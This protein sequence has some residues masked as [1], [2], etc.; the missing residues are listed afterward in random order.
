MWRLRLE[1][2]PSQGSASCSP[3]CGVMPL[4]VSLPRS[5]IL[6][7]SLSLCLSIP[8]LLGRG[9]GR[10]SGLEQNA[11]KATGRMRSDG[12]SRE[13]CGLLTWG[14]FFKMCNFAAA[15]TD[16]FTKG[17]LRCSDTLA[18]APCDAVGWLVPSSA[19]P[20]TIGAMR[21]GKP[22]IILMKGMV[23]QAA[24]SRAMQQ[25][26]KLVHRTTWANTIGITPIVFWSRAGI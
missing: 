20:L 6:S 10:R 13:Q 21:A 3:Q 25:D 12:V 18:Q 1:Q 8:L 17:G 16:E 19:A 7:D 2:A 22:T 23:D 5:F 4:L 26:R 24:A 9:I 15:L 11:C 14:R